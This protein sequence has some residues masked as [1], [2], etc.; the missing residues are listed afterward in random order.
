MALPE[1]GA[2]TKGSSSALFVDYDDAET[3]GL[4]CKAGV[5]DE[6]DVSTAT[7]IMKLSRERL[8][9]LVERFEQDHDRSQPQFDV[10]AQAVQ[11][12]G[13]FVAASYYHKQQKSSSVVDFIQVTN[14][15]FSAVGI[16]SMIGC[17]CYFCYSPCSCCS[18][19]CYFCSR[20]KM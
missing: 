16:K 3:L 17:S 14:V 10:I 9:A 8:Q 15:S 20:L 6:D 2:A 13:G 7:N 4:L 18:C 11:A 1:R 12:R 5:G 19:C